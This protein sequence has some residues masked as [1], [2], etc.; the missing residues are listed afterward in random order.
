MLNAKNK[1]EILHFI[2][3]TLTYPFEEG[4]EQ[5][6]VTVLPHFVYARLTRDFYGFITISALLDRQN[7]H[8]ARLAVR[9]QTAVQ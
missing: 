3:N 6:S 7:E 8:T 1:H 5:C 4:G 9:K 2:D